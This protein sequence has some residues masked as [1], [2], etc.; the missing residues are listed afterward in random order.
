ML[1][2]MLYALMVSALLSLGALLAERAARLRG[3]RTRWIWMA[4]IVLSLLLPTVIASVSVQMPPVL[5]RKAAQPI[6][7]LRNITSEYLSPVTWLAGSAVEPRGWRTFDPHLKRA[8]LAVSVAM[9]LAL[10]ASSAHLMWRKRRWHRSTIAGASVHVTEDVGPAVVGLLRPSIVVPHWLTAAPTTH[11]AAVVAHEQAHVDARDPML[12]TSAL[13]LLVF[14]P[15]NLPLWWQLRRLR[16]AIEVDC[17]ARVL[18]GG[19]DARSYGETLIAVGERRSGYVGAVAAMAESK[20]FLEER[21]QIM[22]T[23]P[24][25]WRRTAIALLAGISV[26]VTVV[27]AQV[28]PPNVEQ[29]E[30]RLGAAVLDRYVGNYLLGEQMVLKVTREGDSLMAQVTG[31]PKVGIFPESETRFFY[32]VVN[33]QLEFTTDG[34]SPATAVVLHQNGNSM[35]AARIDDAAVAQAQSNLDSKV[36]SQVATPGSAELLKRIIAGLQSGNPPYAEMSD[37][38]AAA[39]RK[40]MPGLMQGI[41]SLGAV[42]SVEFRGVDRRGWDLYEVRQANGM[43]QWRIHLASD[44]KADGVLVQ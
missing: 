25:R 43:S 23:K 41:N 42:S 38:L 28:S 5:E 21:L 26:A 33:A 6:V 30:I 17:D 9:L 7:A 32:K 36:R 24:A 40:Q 8:W 11:Q 39:T 29:H 4:A 2:W 31:Q 3:T 37:Q 44:G 16:Y 19:V 14:M 1:A 15:W 35:T 27:A 13:G 18:Q 12:F 34:A 20:S 10:I 22:M